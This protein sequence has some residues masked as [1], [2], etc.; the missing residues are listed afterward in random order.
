MQTFTVTSGQLDT[1]VRAL[2]RIVAAIVA[3]NR[4]PGKHLDILI[5][6]TG[7]EEYETFPTQFIF[8]AMGVETWTVEDQN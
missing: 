5:T 6:V 3:I 2:N 8:Q 4:F 1:R 7:D